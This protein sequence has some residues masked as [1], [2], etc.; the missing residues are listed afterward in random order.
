MENKEDASRGTLVC[1]EGID[2]VGKRTQSSR[3]SSWLASKNLTTT[4]LSFPDY[5][6]K[7]GR[8]I[9]NFL[10]GENNYIPE[11]RAMLYAA[12]R[13]EKNS[14]FQAVLSKHDVV[15]VN[16]YSPS[17]VAY[18]LSNGLNLSWLLNLEDGLPRPDLV[19]VLDAPVESL[20]S[21]RVHNKDVYER[22]VALQERTRRNYLRL[23]AQFGWKVVDASDGIEPT[24]RQ[25]RAAVSQLLAARGR[26][27]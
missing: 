12:N 26:T 15:I 10:I 16:R 13:W 23:A 11:V 18:G 20:S 1:I 22:D 7:I 4:V 8:E 3:L 27:V 9:K 17:N 14:E 5:D 24:G 25:V 2:A 21:R 19:L 6:T